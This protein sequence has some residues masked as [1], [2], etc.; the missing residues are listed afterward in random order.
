MR[1]IKLVND[2]RLL[3]KEL[4]LFYD[5]LNNE[6]DYETGRISLNNFE[7]MLKLSEE[8]RKSLLN[9][10]GSLLQFK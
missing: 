10:F 4:A 5:R 2:Y 7:N 1:D 6:R 3:D 9:D 8:D